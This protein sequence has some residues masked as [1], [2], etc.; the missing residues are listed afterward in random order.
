[1]VLPENISYNELQS[2]YNKY[3]SLS[4]IEGEIDKKFALISLICLL[5]N[6]SK[7]KTPDVTCYQVIRKVL[8]LSKTNLPDDYINGLSIVCEDFL[9]GSTKFN[10]CGLKTP[11]EIVSK[12]KEILDQWLPF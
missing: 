1:M 12:I 6:A 10:N 8:E 11:N 5:T 2:I 7:K 4:G 3:F 9:K